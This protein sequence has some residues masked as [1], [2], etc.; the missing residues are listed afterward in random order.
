[1]PP[2]RHRTSPDG[3]RDAAGRSQDALGSSFSFNA[4]AALLRRRYVKDF[5]FACTKS[6]SGSAGRTCVSYAFLQYGLHVEL[7]R[8]RKLN[9]RLAGLFGARRAARTASSELIEEPEQPPRS[10]P[11]RSI[12][13]WTTLAAGSAAVDNVPAHAA[14]AGVPAVVTGRREKTRVA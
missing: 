14:C 5:C 13:A 12:G 11:G 9:Q 1:M 4:S 8:Y 2:G 7:F 6:V 10:A 3:S